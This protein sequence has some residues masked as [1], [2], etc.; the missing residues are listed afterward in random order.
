M[1]C[2][3]AHGVF[4]FVL[5]ALIAAPAEARRKQQ[6]S[7]A[8]VGESESSDAA[9]ESDSARGNATEET[10]VAED[11]AGDEGARKKRPKLRKRG[12]APEPE[13]EPSDEA[14]PNALELGVGGMALFRRLVWTADADA[15]G[16]GP[17]SLTPGPQAGVWLEFYPA[18]FA[19]GGF[20]ANIGLYAHYDHGFGVSTWTQAGGDVATK[21]EGFVGGLKLRLPLGTFTPFGSVGYGNQSFRITAEGNPLDL[22]GF[23]YSFVR[24]GAGTRVRF[25]SEVALDVGGAFL[26]VSDAGSA[27]GQVASPSFF[28]RTKAYGFELGASLYVHLTSALGIRGGLDWRQYGLA[29]YPEAGD[30]ASRRVAGAVDRYIVTWVGLEVTLARGGGKLE[31]PDD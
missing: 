31:S 9:N 13:P 2:S 6:P 5:A 26:A 8:D 10:E 4:A 12:R 22:P 21:Y 15:A 25:T 28:P 23:A 14:A 1:T 16:L 17:Y 11:E 27:P 19:T 20:A 24:V 7:E 3:A 29:F 18:A 30:S